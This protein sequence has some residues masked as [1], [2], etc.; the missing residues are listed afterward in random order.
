MRAASEL[1]LRCPADSRYVAPLRH[2]LGAF[3]EALEFRRQ[4]IEDVT[5]AAGEALGNIVEHAYATSAKRA[6]QYLELRAKAGRD[7][8]LTIEVS[9]G[10]AFIRRKPLPGRGF[11]LQIIRAIA[12]ELTIE[13]SSGTRVRMTFA[14]KR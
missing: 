4:A 1:R 3:L 11:G 6:E 13:T 8:K 10:G 14:P 2:A 5:T 9:D 12:Q 7:G